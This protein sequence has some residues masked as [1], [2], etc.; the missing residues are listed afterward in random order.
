MER[1]P[2]RQRKRKRSNERVQRKNKSAER[3]EGEGRGETKRRRR[4]S[5]G[6]VQWREWKRGA[7]AQ[8]AHGRIEHAN[9]LWD[10]SFELVLL[11]YPVEHRDERERG[12]PSECI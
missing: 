1:P 12:K 3:I 6:S 4:G 2:R 8:V 11:Q 9:F 10:W 7:Y 5:G